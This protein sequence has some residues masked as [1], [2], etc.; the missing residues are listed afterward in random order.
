MGC[1]KSKISNTLPKVG[2]VVVR[3]MTTGPIE[4]REYINPRKCKVIYVNESKGWYEVEFLDTKIREC[5]SIP[6]FDHS[7]LSGLS[8][9]MIPVIC[10]ETGYVYGSMFDC[11]KDMG[12]FANGISRCIAGS[13]DAYCGYHFDTAL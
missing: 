9:R 5:Y 1:I 3:V 12:L 11:A 13:I 7:I 4:N 6:T 10:V 2:D 8:W